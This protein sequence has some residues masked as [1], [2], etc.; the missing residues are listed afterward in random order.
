LRNAEQI[1][2]TVFEGHPKDFNIGLWDGTLI[3]WSDSPKF[4]L[5]FKDK[6]TFKRVLISSDAY[7]AGKAFVDGNVDITGDLFEAIKLSDHLSQLRL[8]F[9]EKMKMLLEVMRL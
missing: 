3:K 4:T 7:K 6:T 9:I 5:T 1:L 2:E 8:G